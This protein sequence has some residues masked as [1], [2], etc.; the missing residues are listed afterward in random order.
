MKVAVIGVGNMGRHHARVYSELANVKLVAIADINE[1]AGYEIAEKY[2][3]NYYKD[4]RR[5]LSTSK[6]D[7]VSIAVPTNLHREVAIECCKRKIHI[8]VEKPIADTVQSAQEM[9][10]CAKNNNT[11]LFVGHIE[12]F[13]PVVQELKKLVRH[14]IFGKIITISTKRVGLFPSQ[15]KDANVITDLA[16]H[17]IDICNFLL[18]EQ[19]K[20]VFTRA[21]KALNSKRIDYAT[22]NMIYKNTEAILQVNWI[23]PIKVRELALTGEKG[24]VEI[25]YLNQSMKIYKSNYEKT[26]DSY[27][28]Y[29]VKFGVP[30]TI[31]RHLPA[32]EPLKEEIKNFLGVISN[33]RATIISGEE[34]L[35]ALKICLKA[36]ESFNERKVKEITL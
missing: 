17:D 21:G 1:K 14:K 7:A 24:Y 12:R 20:Y 27:G 28:D 34:G 9:I 3:C 30:D 33:R 29:I 36:I 2:K 15:I 10:N 22:I 19:P 11:L 18:Q 16:V 31:E 23:T 26:F 8:L 4:Y 6:I 25:N 13:N 35:N 5:M 32:K